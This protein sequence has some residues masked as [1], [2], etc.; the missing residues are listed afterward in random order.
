MRLVQC[1]DCGAYERI[2]DDERPR[3]CLFCGGTMRGRR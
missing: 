1:K 2:K 3:N